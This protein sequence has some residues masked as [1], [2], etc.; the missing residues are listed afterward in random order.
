MLALRLLAVDHP[1]NYAAA[2]SEA[3]DDSLDHHYSVH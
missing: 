1:Q 2:W 3:D